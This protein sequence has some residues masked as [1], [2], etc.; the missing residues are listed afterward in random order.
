MKPSGVCVAE[1]VAGREALESK[2]RLA[3]ALVCGVGNLHGD[4]PHSSEEPRKTV[5]WTASD[6]G[7]FPGAK[8][9]TVAGADGFRDVLCGNRVA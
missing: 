1:E 8:T 6:S 4:Q 3:R 7:R 5:P 9:A 2:P